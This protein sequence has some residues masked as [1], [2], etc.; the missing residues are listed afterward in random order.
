MFHLLR[1]VGA[2]IVWPLIKFFD[3]GDEGRGIG[4]AEEL[5][6]RAKHLESFLVK[7]F[8]AT[9]GFICQAH[10]VFVLAR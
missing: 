2:K 6:S 7:L 8:F 4:F 5:D 1:S 3:L 10:N 9:T